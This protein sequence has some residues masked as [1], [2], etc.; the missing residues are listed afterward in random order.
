M[1]TFKKLWGYMG[2]R[3]ALLPVAIVLSALSGLAGLLP[4][5]FI[6]LIARELLSG[7]DS[8]SQSSVISY[9]WWAAGTAAGSVALYFGALMCSHLA[10]FR[11]ESNIRK[12]AMRRVIAMPLGFFDANTSGR[13]RKIIDD[14]AGI[15]HS[16]L[17]HQL[18]DLAGTALVPI[19]AIVLI[20]AFDWRLG[21]ACLIP[22]FIAMG[23][24]AYT[25]NTRGREF[26]KEYMTLLERMNTEAV[27]YVRG[28]PVVKVFQQTV[29]SFKNFYRT[30]MQYSHTLHTPVG[31]A[32]D[33]LHGHH[34]Q[35]CLHS[36]ARSNH[37]DRGRRRP[38]LRNYQ[39]HTVRARY[40]GV[41]GVRHEEH[42]HRPGLGAG[43][44]GCTPP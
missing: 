40:A 6:W 34:Q 3:R 11:V 36:R 37:H 29:F 15:T 13:I 31:T 21:L 33:P 24:M 18:P 9:A 39:P 20:A 7:D 17:A 28:I 10:A 35:L 38:G 23:I 42:V 25:M 19:A 44:R 26:M 2:R 22:V 27:E 32:D 14:N 30:I 1:T 5:V 8:A 12:S 4:F 41:L 16:F 43:R